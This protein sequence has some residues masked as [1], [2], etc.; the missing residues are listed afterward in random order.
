MP[1]PV[2]SVIA[3]AG[4]A[5]AITDALVAL[6]SVAMDKYEAQKKAQFPPR[7]KEAILAFIKGDL[8][9]LV[10]AILTG[11]ADAALARAALIKNL[12]LVGIAADS[13]M[14]NCGVA[15]FELGVTAYD[16][17]TTAVKVAR[18]GSMAASTGVGAAPAEVLV[19]ATFLYAVF[20]ITKD[21][22]NAANKCDGL[23]SRKAAENK[24]PTAVIDGRGRNLG[25]ISTQGRSA[26]GASARMFPD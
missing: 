23:I 15:L 7:F 12:D 20:L 9:L 1:N 19:A 22:L 16:E 10:P 5:T 2:V 18:L 8:N 26:R 25:E 24:S 6:V 17:C 14:V 11:K 13:E 4:G 3:R 21:A